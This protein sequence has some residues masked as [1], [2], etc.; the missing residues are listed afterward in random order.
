MRGLLIFFACLAVGVVTADQCSF[1]YDTA[2][3]GPVYHSE[4]AVDGAW[5]LLLVPGF[6]SP[7]RGRVLP[8]VRLGPALPMFRIQRVS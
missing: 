1:N 6:I 2:Y 3:G 5:V 4:M 8:H 7:P